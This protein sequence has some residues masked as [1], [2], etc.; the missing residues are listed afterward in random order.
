[1]SMFDYVHFDGKVYQTKDLEMEMHRFLIEDGQLLK[2]TYANPPERRVFIGNYPVDFT[3]Y[4]YLCLDGS[5]PPD[6]NIFFKMRFEDGRA[7]GP[8]ETSHMDDG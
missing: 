7:V 6:V 2:R 5:H 4:L 1:M 8:L 3:G